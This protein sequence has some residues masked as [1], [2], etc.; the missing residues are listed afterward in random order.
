MPWYH[1]RLSS[2]TTLLLALG[3]CACAPKPPEQWPGRSTAPAPDTERRVASVIEPVP[4]P[5]YS[6]IDQLALVNGDPVPADNHEPFR[7][8]LTVRITPSALAAYRDWRVGGVMPEGTWIVAEHYARQG[9]ARGPY[10]SA[11]KSTAG[12]Q[13]GAAMPDGG[14]VPPDAACFACH[15]EAPADFVFGLARRAAPRAQIDQRPDGG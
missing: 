5:E 14:L 12:W 1:G 3:L 9:G 2:R 15:S 4:W 6:R 7:W 10:Y 11:N 13:F 8:N